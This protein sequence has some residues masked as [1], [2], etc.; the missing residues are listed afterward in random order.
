MKCL[1]DNFQ[2]TVAKFAS[3]FFFE[4]SISVWCNTCLNIYKC[5]KCII[6][7]YSRSLITLH[8]CFVLAVSIVTPPRPYS[9][10]Y[11]GRHHSKF[12]VKAAQA[13]PFSKKKKVKMPRQKCPW[14]T[15]FRFGRRQRRH[16]ILR[17]TLRFVR[18]T[19]ECVRLFWVTFCRLNVTS[20][21]GRCTE[22]WYRALCTP[23]SA[24]SNTVHRHLDVSFFL[25]SI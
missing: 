7:V 4:V 5:N 21:I 24:P 19:F 12:V 14:S 20:W 1:L 23:L 18:S 13:S 3:G 25:H 8:T 11:Y 17:R 2:P 15:L 6:L 16:V 10:Y 9:N 22:K